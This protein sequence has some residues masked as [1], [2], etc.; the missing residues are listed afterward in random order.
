MR[1]RTLA[2]LFLVVAALLAFIWF[3]E[4]ELPS[5]DE[6]VELAR[7]VLRLEAE[8]VRGV[9]VVRG[10]QRLRLE[11]RTA[12]PVAEGEA[13]PA[14]GWWLR[15]P[16]S[17]AAD[18]S[19]VDRLVE[20]LVGLEK[21]RTLTDAD[22][23]ELGLG[24]PRARVLLETGTGTVELLVGSEVPASTTMIVAVAERDE[25]YVVADRLWG[26]LTKP[27]GDWRNRDLGPSSREAIQRLVLIDGDRRV[28]LGRRGES[29]WVESPYSDRADRD[30]V[31]G[32]LGAIMGMRVES[33]VDDPAEGLAAFGLEPPHGVVEVV[34]DGR[35][36]AL[37]LEL[38]APAG[39]E[40]DL[41]FARSDGQ[42][43]ETRTDLADAV[44]RPAE[45]WRAL[46]W[47]SFEVYQIDRVEVRDE[48]GD[49][50]FERQAGDW[51]RDGARVE[52]SP[53]SDFLYALSGV[54]ADSVL[55][56]AAPAGQPLLTLVLSGEEDRQE[57]L[58]L[59]GPRAEGAS[60]A[61]VSGREVTLALGEGTVSDLRLKLDE[62]RRAAVPSADDAAAE[63]EAVGAD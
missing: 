29:F 30:L 27:A 45:E 38:G 6:R 53:V 18:A 37:R 8:E 44:A 20:D 35:D 10:D 50:V 40:G 7:K 1:P 11:R 28:A 42:L 16:L 21:G 31:S 25:A 61:R 33:F 17:G 62:A 51:L 49:T 19:A 56:A 2:V 23:E 4:R 52:Y 24:E 57:T 5:S 26:E 60:P 14:A 39:D 47:T 9:T 46:A 32:L 3:Y 54:E 13:A 48:A 59:Y 22:R 12:P 58:T 41:R 15:E 43:F 34:L 36:E 63:L 55:G